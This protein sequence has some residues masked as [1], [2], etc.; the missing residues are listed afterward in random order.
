MPEKAKRI[1]GIKGWL[2]VYLILIIL[3]S[4]GS[5]FLLIE[6]IIQ[7]NITTTEEVGIIA[8]HL[9]YFGGIFV[10]GTYCVYSILAKK[11]NAKKVNKSFLIMIIV[12]Q[13]ISFFISGDPLGNLMGIILAAFFLRYW[14]KSERIKNTFVI[15]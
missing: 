5:L 13:A 7:S 12:L 10:L 6:K 15:N 2:L 4:L 3:L 1:T 8:G 11:K 9:V 14:G